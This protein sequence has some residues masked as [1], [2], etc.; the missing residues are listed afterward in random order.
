MWQQ[1]QAGS[2]SRVGAAVRPPANYTEDVQAAKPLHRPAGSTR[3]APDAAVRRRL[4]SATLVVLLAVTDLTVAPHARGDDEAPQSPE[5]VRQQL[6]AADERLRRLQTEIEAS[7]Q[8]RAA[9]QSSLEANAEKLGERRQ[10]VAAL[11]QDIAD[12][13][14]RLD[15]LEAE[16]QAASQ[17]ASA[18]RRL[19]VETLRRA[20]RIADNGGLKALLQH[21]NPALANRLG[22]Y[23]DYTLRA[24]RAAIRTQLAALER[25]ETAAATARKDRNWLNYIQRKASSQRDALAVSEADQRRDLEAVDSR[26]SE[27]TRTVAELRADQQR[28]Q[29]LMD[30]LEKAQAAGSGYFAGGKGQWP[31]PVAGTIEARF[32]ETKAVG[33]ITWNGLFIS[34]DAGRPVR[35]I[36]D[37]EVVYSDWLNGFGMLVIVDHGDAWMSLY[38]GNRE[39]LVDTG[40]WVESGTTIATIGN[41]ITH[42]TDGRRS[43]GVYFEIR[44]DAVPVDPADWVSEDRGA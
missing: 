5:L 7:R 4:V 8:R 42:E 11:A 31:L 23:T 3:P 28:L 34:A 33:H 20:Q 30:E 44:H 15:R 24:Q 37:G 36:A 29:S 18:R 25:I 1:R 40:T 10:R 27:K 2:F 16:L 26:L 12:F 6:E 32:G 38:G 22:V 35:T 17:S 13:D 39:V 41:G 14:A 43:S 21:D 9:L 19:L